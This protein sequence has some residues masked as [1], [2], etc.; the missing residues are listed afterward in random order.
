[1]FLRKFKIIRNIIINRFHKK[2][3]KAII[4]REKENDNI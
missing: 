3:Y 2:F 1:M 4:K